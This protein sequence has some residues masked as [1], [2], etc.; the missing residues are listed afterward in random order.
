MAVNRYGKITRNTGGT[1]ARVSN[2]PK[3]EQQSVVQE[4]EN[5]KP[6]FNRTLSPLQNLVRYADDMK[7]RQ[8]LANDYN[9]VKNAQTQ[10]TLERLGQTDVARGSNSYAVEQAKR[11]NLLSGILNTIADNEKVGNL[12]TFLTGSATPSYNEFRRQQDEAMK[13]TLTNEMQRA[14][15]TQE[16]I[17]RWNRQQNNAERQEVLSNYAKTHPVLAT[18]NAFPENIAGSAEGVLDKLTSYVTGNPLEAKPSNAEIYRNAVS[19]GIDSK[20]GN[21]A[22]GVGNSIGDMLLAQLVTGGLG[23][24]KVG[25]ALMGLEKADPVMNSAIERGL[26]PTQTL[27]EGAG[28]GLTTAITEAIPFG[29]F[30]EG[31]HILGS[32]AAEGLQEGAEDI[33]DTLLDRLV[34]GVGGNSEKSEWNQNIQA[35]IDAGYTEEE[36]RQA[37][38]NDYLKQLGLDIAAGA[39]SGGVMQGG[40]NALNQRNLITGKDRIPQ[41]TNEQLESI[42]EVDEKGNPVKSE[43]E[44]KAENERKQRQSVENDSVLQYLNVLKENVKNDP[45]QYDNWINVAKQLQT[46]RPEIDRQIREQYADLRGYLDNY[47]EEQ[48][49][50]AEER[51][52]YNDPETLDFLRGIASDISNE[53][54]NWET[55]AEQLDRIENR[56]AE[57][58]ASE[59]EKVLRDIENQNP[60]AGEGVYNFE[61]YIQTLIQQNPE[62]AG[63][64]NAELNDVKNASEGWVTD[65]SR[66]RRNERPA[67]PIPSLAFNS[68][69]DAQSYL[70]DITRE[71]N[72]AEIIRREEA[73]VLNSLN[74]PDSLEKVSKFV[75]RMNF[76][77]Q[78]NPT[79]RGVVNNA[80]NEVNART[81]GLVEDY[82]RRQIQSGNTAFNSQTEAK[83]YIE[84][85][86]QDDAE[87]REIEQRIGDFL[88]KMSNNTATRE[89]AESMA[90]DVTTMVQ[91]LPAEQ[92]D[93]VADMVHEAATAYREFHE[94]E[95]L[96]REIANLGEEDV[97]PVMNRTLENLDKALRFNLKFF[98]EKADTDIP[99][100]KNNEVNTGK[101]KTSKFPNNSFKRSGIMTDEEIDANIPEEDKLYQEV[102]DKAAEDKARENI[103]ENGYANEIDKVINNDNWDKVDSNVARLCAY[104]A[105][106]DARKAV[107][108]GVDPK[109]AW[110][111]SVDIFKQARRQATKGGQLIQSF[112][113]WTSMTPEGKLAQAIAYVNETAKE[114]KNDPWNKIVK[115]AQTA[116]DVYFTDE[117]IAE[118]LN[119]AHQYDGQ[120]VSLARQA[121]LNAEL[122]HMIN[123]QIPVKFQQKFTSLW[124]DNLLASFRTLISR[125]FGGNIGKA[126]LDQTLVK[127]FSGPIDNFL[128]KYTGTRTTTGFTMEGLKTYG[129]GFKKGAKQTITDYWTPNADPDTEAK[130]TDLA[131]E[132]DVFADANV[133]NRSGVNEDSFKESLSNNHPVFKNKALKLYDK[134]IKFGLAI[135]D[136][137]FY[138]GAYDQTVLELNTLR[139]QGKLD[140][141]EDITDEQFDSWVKAI[142]TAQGLEAVY[143]DNT[144]LADGA[145]KIKQG[146]GEM[147]EGYIGVDILSGASMPFVRT[148]MN[149]IK[150]NLELSP[151]GIVKNAIQTISEIR[152]NLE[153]GRSALDS[154]SFKQARFVRETSRNLVGL[155]LFATG[156]ALKNA[157]LLTGGYSDDDR[158]K[159]A[160]KESGMQEYALVNPFNGNQ[161]SI[162]WIPGLGS[163]LVSASAFDDAYNKPDQDGI[164]A[165]A[166]GIK[167]GSASMF[168]MAALQGLQRLT[169]SA[170]YNS[171]NSLIDN[172]AQTVANTAS[173]AILPSIVRQTA[174][175]LDP[176]KRNTYGT[177]GKESVFNNAIAGIPFLRE[178]MLQPRIGLNGQP[179]EQ[180]AGRNGFE[181]WFDNL[182]NPAMVTVPSALADPVRDEAT[183]L[184]EAT[185]SSSA[186]QPKIGINS[187]KT[188]DHTPTTEEYTEFLQIADGA[189]NQVA[190]ELIQS[191]YYAG[192]T[193][194]Q[195]VDTLN[196]IYTAVQ[197]V[198]K[199]RYLGTDKEFNGASKAYD[200]GGTQGLIDY[201][202]AKNALAG[203]GAQNNPENRE[204]ITETINNGTF[205]DMEQL[206]F[207]VNLIKKYQHAADRIPSLNPTTF[208]QQFNAID[209][210]IDGTGNNSITQKEIIAYLNQNPTGYNEDEA[211]RIW[212]AYLQSYGKIPVFDPDK[213]TWSAK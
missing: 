177:G 71:D 17:D 47:E 157:G 60:L 171:D 207:D 34:T 167:A 19:S 23:K 113:Q 121:R 105:A 186:Y 116:A 36:A 80:L 78:N 175:A 205:D 87:I 151:L 106:N 187:L 137:P 81:N 42:P 178:Q 62:M 38:K 100:V 14:G 97:Q 69:E 24:G 147:S 1:N 145:A 125:N 206:G 159:Q 209:T 197:S 68:R 168:E 25:A 70:N 11:G 120:N 140:L 164:D 31:G 45:S 122:A 88:A 20:L 43:E 118:F 66:Y 15:L 13:G 193:D 49:R 51:A 189:M 181:K 58:V 202:V 77:A 133:T 61:K 138:K 82:S 195:R 141:P 169:G 110:K 64:L 184:Y 196:S 204:L 146:L 129:R 104:K 201:F 26:T 152:A 198:E 35:Y 95:G 203:M 111:Q 33:A 211:L 117:F 174:A 131:K 162:N 86:K 124:M 57:E 126:A 5:A 74:A 182:V 52:R 112:K 4:Y 199:A 98:S 29:R 170:N 6:T 50:Q 89:D 185:G 79:M 163:S 123:N 22:Y 150:T 192:L 91:S 65:Y 136:N 154:T 76:I 144:K 59:K 161:Y 165:L 158:E 132:I 134:I 44:V 28:S 212:D 10:Q 109:E 56:V 7:T 83:N 99:Q 30:A 148:P 194:E 46:E 9:T 213:G 85:V 149:V 18:L 114:D 176:Y 191:D 156:L 179:M 160:Q 92:Q 208:Q 37:V 103:K 180:N 210:S 155:I 173:S 67:K 3:L 73:D 172:V 53:S 135:G 190:S 84:D 90:N 27:A 8:A 40:T 119:K 39:V 200:E 96:D 102:T 2:I 139:E 108:L 48:A 12:T 128:S 21:F 16:D 153:N 142:A 188:E 107:G 130:L 143:Q 72:L 94:N 32:M 166:N 101:Y 41:L 183:R 55:R 54:Q 127:M 115:D 75:T 63:Y 93:N